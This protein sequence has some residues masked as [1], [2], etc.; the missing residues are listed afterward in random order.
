MGVLLIMVVLGRCSELFIKLAYLSM[1][2]KSFLQELRN[3]KNVKNVNM[4]NQDFSQKNHLQCDLCKKCEMQ[5]FAYAR[6]MRKMWEER[7]MWEKQ[8]MRE[9]FAIS[10]ILI[11]R[12]RENFSLFLWFFMFFAFI[13]LCENFSHYAKKVRN[14]ICEKWEMREIMR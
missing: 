13:V 10:R 12:N 6:I 3:L 2:D 9:I 8:E 14:A 5:E 7:E 4:H 11:A 1:C